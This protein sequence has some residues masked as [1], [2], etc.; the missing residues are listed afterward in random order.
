MSKAARSSTST[1]ESLSLTPLISSLEDLKTRLAGTGTHLCL[2][3][4]DELPYSLFKECIA[5]GVSKVNVNS[6]CRDAYVAALQSGLEEGKAYPDALED[7]V[8][9]FRAVAEQLCD[10]FGSSGKA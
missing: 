1:C 7:A 10:V 8:A 9:A 5:A 6:W 3:G 4:T 2:H